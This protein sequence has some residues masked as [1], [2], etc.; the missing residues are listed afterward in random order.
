MLRPLA[1]ELDRVLAPGGLLI[2]SG[3]LAAEH[4]EMV[5]RYTSLARTLR[6]VE[7][8]RRGD[9]TGDDWTALAFVA[10]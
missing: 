6:H 2:L 7:T 3:V 8:R 5:E 9:G 1:P 4:D 10:S